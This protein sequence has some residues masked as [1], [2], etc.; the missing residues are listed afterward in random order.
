MSAQ[1]SAILK[2]ETYKEHGRRRAGEHARE[3]HDLDAREGP[4]SLGRRE[5][6]RERAG[7]RAKGG[8]S[9]E[10]SRVVE[11][12]GVQRGECSGESSRA[13]YSR[14]TR[15]ARRVGVRPTAYGPRPTAY[16]PADV[17]ARPWALLADVGGANRPC[18]RDPVGTPRQRRTL[19]RRSVPF[20]DAGD[21]A[22]ACRPYT[23]GVHARSVSLIVA[24]AARRPRYRRCGLGATSTAKPEYR[25]II[26][27]QS[28]SN[29]S[30]RNVLRALPPAST[31]A[32]QQDA[33]THGG[34]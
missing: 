15:A 10:H 5:C 24:A 17:I 12:F 25:A 16:G 18:P 19:R 28:V 20:V 33:R 7:R 6:A 9:E 23:W 31:T 32:L 22:A 4:V 21:L 2:L 14:E 1:L 34:Y 8:Q 3:V 11:L 13:S 30:R 26:S 29:R 27:C